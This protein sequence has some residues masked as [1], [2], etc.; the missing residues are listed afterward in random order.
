MKKMWCKATILKEKNKMNWK[1]WIATYFIFV[2]SVIYWDINRHV[3]ESIDLKS[4]CHNAEVREINKKY[5]C[6][7]CEKYCEVK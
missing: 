5:V 2:A 7:K 4:K 3:V 6:S 1:T